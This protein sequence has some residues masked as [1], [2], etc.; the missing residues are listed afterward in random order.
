MMVEAL[1]EISVPVPPP[2]GATEK[3]STSGTTPAPAEAKTS[4]QQDPLTNVLP[5]VTESG[6][7]VAAP[8]SDT[9]S[10][11]RASETTSVSE[12]FSS[13]PSSRH[14][15]EGSEAGAETEEDEGMVLVGRPQL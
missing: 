15:N 5:S 13:P 4:T 8:D 2:G 12:D 11:S 6:P 9:R 10:E 3:P 14:G 7:D 1:R